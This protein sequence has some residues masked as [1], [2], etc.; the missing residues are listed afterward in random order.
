M[1][2]YPFPT[3][4]D[5]LKYNFN[6]K[7]IKNH[8]GERVVYEVTFICGSYDVF[9][10][11][12]YTAGV[13]VGVDNEFAAWLQPGDSVTLQTDD[14]SSVCWQDGGAAAY[15]TITFHSPITYTVQLQ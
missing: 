1:P 13:S 8:F 9:G 11:T 6:S 3:K 12:P 14:L 4:G 15:L 5:G 2:S 7:G 10:K